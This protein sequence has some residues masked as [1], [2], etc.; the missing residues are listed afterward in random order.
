MLYKLIDVQV[1]RLRCGGFIFAI[2][3]NHVM[4]D[5]GGMIQLMFAIAEIGRGAAI[6][7]SIPPVWE[8]HLLNARDPPRV[9]FSHREYD[10]Q[11]EQGSVTSENIV[12]RS[13]FFGP[14]EV[15]TLRN[16]LPN[17]LRRQ[18]SRFEL[19]AAC[20]WRC[21]TKAII[22]PNDEDEEVRMLCMFNAR[23]KFNP[24]LP[25]GYYGN[26]AVFPAA[27]TTARKLCYNPLGY[28]VRLVRQAKESVT[29]EYV[30]SVADLMVIKG[31]AHHMLVRY[32]VVSDVSRA[33]F[34]NVDFGWG[35]AVY[36]GIAKGGLGA[37]AE[38]YA[39]SFLIA[40]KNGIVMPICLPAESMERFAMELDRM[41]KK[42]PLDLQSE[43][44]MISSA[45]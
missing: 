42:E 11:V 29:E 43:S 45:L 2:S 5:A 22:K 26:A 10:D 24:P 37:V 27:I 28:A 35:K 7:P 21:R 12:H 39:S 30:K 41:L 14:E 20:L 3:V 13:F 25:S 16:Q 40:I 36:G 32:C 33:G 4:S 44:V 38:A 19:L 31:R 9:S 18:C 23:S 34:G 17:H 6:T 15:S 1:T 8:R